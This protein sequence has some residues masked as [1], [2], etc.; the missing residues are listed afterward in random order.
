[1]CSGVRKSKSGS[2]DV[3]S[4]SQSKK[5]EQDIIFVIRPNHVCSPRFGNSVED[6]IRLPRQQLH[7]LLGMLIGFLYA[8]PN[9]AVVDLCVLTQGGELL[10][11]RVYA[12]TQCCDVTVAL[13]DV[14]MGSPEPSKNNRMLLVEEGLLRSSEALYL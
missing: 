11:L 1:V 5:Q 8:R 7:P 2:N 12:A 13:L 14:V 9:S 3:F 6:E 10:R 4:D